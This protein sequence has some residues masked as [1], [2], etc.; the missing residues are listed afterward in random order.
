MEDKLAQAEKAAK[1]GNSKNIIPNSERSIW[2]NM[3][4]GTSC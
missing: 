1:M 2:E 4:I 3:F